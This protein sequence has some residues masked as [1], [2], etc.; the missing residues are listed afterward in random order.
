LLSYLKDGE[1]SFIDLTLV[2][3]E[4]MP[5]IIAK[6][7]ADGPK[8]GLVLTHDGQHSKLYADRLGIS[9]KERAVVPRLAVKQWRKEDFDHPGS[10]R[11]KEGP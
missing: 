6:S 10:G 7:P 11:G 8:K 3:Y 5:L 2:R 9:A 1:N 4:G